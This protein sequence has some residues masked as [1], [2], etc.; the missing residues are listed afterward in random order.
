MKTILML[1]LYLVF[2]INNYEIIMHED[3]NKIVSISLKGDNE[4]WLFSGK[5]AHHVVQYSLEQKRVIKK[6]IGKGKGPLEAE[7]I[8]YGVLNEKD[9]S[10][11]IKKTNG[12]LLK[13]SSDGQLIKY[14]GDVSITSILQTNYLQF[15]ENEILLSC[16]SDLTISSLKNNSSIVVGYILDSNT[17]EIKSEVKIP[18]SLIDYDESIKTLR[19]IFIS[20][21]V[22]RISNKEF[23]IFIQGLNKYIIYNVFKNTYTEKK[24]NLKRFFKIKAKK[25][26]QFDIWGSQYCAINNSCV[27]TDKKVYTF[28]GNKHQEIPFGYFEIDLTNK[29]IS[30]VILIDDDYEEITELKGYIKNNKIFLYNN[31]FQNSYIIYY[32]D[33]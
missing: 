27:I 3:I 29:N 18:T 17:L 20:S 5:D 28:F 7:L 26:P 23:Y 4:L 14:N 9:N 16:M 15:Y 33:L 2:Y 13:V 11:F 1:I 21:Y 25:N 22:F 32:K 19:N 31:Y 10:I 30:Q 8:D 24:L 12:G 6:M